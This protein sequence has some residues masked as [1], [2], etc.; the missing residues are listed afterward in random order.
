MEVGPTFDAL[1][2][3]TAAVASALLFNCG[4]HDDRLLADVFFLK[5]LAL[6]CGVGLISNMPAP[7]INIG[8]FLLSWKSAFLNRGERI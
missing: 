6:C 1:S 7:S 3:C 8:P 2:E 4:C 5:M